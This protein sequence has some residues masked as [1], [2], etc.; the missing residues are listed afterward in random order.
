[1]RSFATANDNHPSR[2]VKLRVED[3]APAKTNAKADSGM[4][5][6]EA[7]ARTTAVFD[8]AKR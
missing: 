7:K 4:T 6:R 3:G 1:M 8:C 5:T 2:A